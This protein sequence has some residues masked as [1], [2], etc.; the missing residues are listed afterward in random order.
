MKYSM[1][2][3]CVISLLACQSE[4]KAESQESDQESTSTAALSQVDID[5]INYKDYV[6]SS[7]AKSTLES[8]K[9]YSELSRHINALKKADL[10]FFK[11][12]EEIMKGFIEEFKTGMPDAISTESIKARVLV[13]ENDLLKMQSLANLS[14]IKKA[15]LLKAV[16]DLF[17]AYA[18]L[19]LQINKKF[20]LESQNIEI[21]Y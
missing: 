15:E 8:W 11:S 18:N 7:E 21:P 1:L 4:P 2:L 13:V 17:L 10:S 12:E 3:L 6:L 20:E 14:N 5:A 19:N 16:E 9:N